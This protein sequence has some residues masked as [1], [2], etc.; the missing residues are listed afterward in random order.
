MKLAIA[1]VACLFINVQYSFSHHSNRW[2]FNAGGGIK[3]VV[4]GNSAHTDHIEMSGL[5]SS[6]IITYGVDS[7]CGLVSQ[8]EVEDLTLRT[9]VYFKCH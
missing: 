3:W 7:A 8:Q 6:A 9:I 1:I 4:R 2:V 5:Q